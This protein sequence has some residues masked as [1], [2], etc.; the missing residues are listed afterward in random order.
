MIKEAEKAVAAGE[1]RQAK[2]LYREV[3][4]AFIATLS[5]LTRLTRREVDLVEPPFTKLEVRLQRL[6][7]MVSARRN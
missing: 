7:S 5:E 3:D 4:R 6:S 1:V 2:L